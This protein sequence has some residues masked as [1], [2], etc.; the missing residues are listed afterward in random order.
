[1]VNLAHTA[2]GLLI[3]GIFAVSLLNP[4]GTM[5]AL[6]IALLVI[7]AMLLVPFV[8]EYVLSVN[9]GK[10]ARKTPST[11]DANGEKK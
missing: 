2:I 4:G 10:A 7:G 1:M 3:I 5:V 9:K 8:Q 6:V 11:S